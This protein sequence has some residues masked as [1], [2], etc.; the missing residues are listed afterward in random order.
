MLMD[1]QTIVQIFYKM[2]K[3]RLFEEKAVMFQQRGL[4][5]SPLYLSIG[6]EAT[7]AAVCALGGDDAIFASHRNFAVAIAAD[8][9][10]VTILAELAGL[11][12]GLCGGNAGGACYADNSVNFY[13]ATAL[14][15]GNFAKAVGTALSFKL[16][17]R[18]SCV[19]CFAGDGASSDGSFYEALNMAALYQLPVIFFIEN[20]CYGGRGRV[21][22][23]HNVRDIA[24]RAKGFEIP[25]I[26]VDG[27]NAIEVYGGMMSGLE[28]AK[29]NQSPVVIESKTYRLAGHTLEDNQ[30]Y[31]TNEEIAQWVDYDA[32]DNITSYMI[33]NGIGITEDL[34]MMRKKIEDELS[35]AADYV[36]SLIQNETRTAQ[37]Y[38]EAAN[39]EQKSGDA[40]VFTEH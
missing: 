16:Q 7:A 6:Q 24:E 39:G 10:A 5:S 14:A 31:R 23:L 12:E 18:E 13:G 2:L 21:D 33:E 29:K 35:G 32:I 17:G 40:F 1:N 4:V 11:E 25:G 15:G 30:S 3:A 28:Y 22:Q 9:S 34:K 19:A 8:V 27:N 38:A 20:N 37:P 36:M 26:I